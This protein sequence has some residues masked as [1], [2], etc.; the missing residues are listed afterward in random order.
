M[1]SLEMPPDDNPLVDYH[2]VYI[3]ASIVIYYLGGYGVLGLDGRWS[4]LSIVERF[5]ILR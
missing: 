2:I 5:P 3:L 4:E 1:F